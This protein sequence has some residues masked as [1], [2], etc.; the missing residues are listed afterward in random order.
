MGN[1][2][3]WIGDGITWAGSEVLKYGLSGLF[4]IAS[5]LCEFIVTECTGSFV[6]F[7]IAGGLVYIC[8]GNKIGMKMIRISIATFV[9]MQVVGVMF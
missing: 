6:V 7:A 1:V 8:G 4:S 9:V 5:N 2:L 3:G